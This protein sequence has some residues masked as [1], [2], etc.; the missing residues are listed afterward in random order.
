MV[1]LTVLANILVNVRLNVFYKLIRLWV[2]SCAID[3]LDT[4]QVVDLMHQI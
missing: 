3:F 4:H 1:L 2:V